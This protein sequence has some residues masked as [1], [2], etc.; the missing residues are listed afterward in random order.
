MNRRI[1]L[2][3]AFKNF[4]SNDTYAVTDLNVLN[5]DTYH[6]IRAISVGRASLFIKL[7][8]AGSVLNG[9]FLLFL[10]FFLLLLLSYIIVILNDCKVD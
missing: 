8:V 7:Q 9:S 3:I 1:F 10:S 6:K 5:V 2:V 4:N